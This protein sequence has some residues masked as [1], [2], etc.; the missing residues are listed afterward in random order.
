MK[1]Y[2]PLIHALIDALRLLEFAG[3][4]EINPDTAVRGMENIASSLLIRDECDQITLRDYFEQIAD[5]AQDHAY[6]KFVRSLPDMLG[7]AAG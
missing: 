4:E 5:N 7:L 6:K 2:L 3:P 1:N